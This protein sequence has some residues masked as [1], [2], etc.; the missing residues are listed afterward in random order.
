MTDVAEALSSALEESRWTCE[1]SPSRAT[2][3]D[4]EWALRSRRGENAEE[5]VARAKSAAARVRIRYD[6]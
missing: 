4:A 1:S 3:T 6:S 5:A 2:L